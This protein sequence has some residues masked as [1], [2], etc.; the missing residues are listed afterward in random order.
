M[1]GIWTLVPFCDIF[2]RSHVM[3]TGP[4]LFQE[5][6]MRR[7]MES[8][9]TFPGAK[10]QRIGHARQTFL[11]SPWNPLHTGPRPCMRLRL[12]GRQS[13]HPR[14]LPGAPMEI[15]RQ[16]GQ[17]SRLCMVFQ[18]HPQ[19]LHVSCCVCVIFLSCRGSPRCQKDVLG[20]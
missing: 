20:F 13:E 19:P 9:P 10:Q 12:P 3:C 15:L 4:E 16:T 18:R 11:P 6:T 14:P 17:L 5:E 1:G 7:R 2:W 8:F